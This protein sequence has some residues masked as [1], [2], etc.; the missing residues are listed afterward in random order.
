MSQGLTAIIAHYHSEWRLLQVNIQAFGS[1]MLRRMAAVSRTTVS[2]KA[3]VTSSLAWN[4]PPMM[5][6]G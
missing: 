3:L 4:F 6:S 2:S 1:A 5:P